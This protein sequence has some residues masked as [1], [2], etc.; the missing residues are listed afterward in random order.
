MLWQISTVDIFFRFLVE[1]STQWILLFKQVSYV[2]EEVA[3]E[4]LERNEDWIEKDLTWV[5][6]A[7]LNKIDIIHLPNKQY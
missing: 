1:I 4:V 6:V 7:E 3:E 5:E 2:R